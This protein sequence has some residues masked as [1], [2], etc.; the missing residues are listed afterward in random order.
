VVQ[1]RY[2]V[3]G[4]QGGALI[5]RFLFTCLVTHGPSCCLVRS[6]FAISTELLLDA[7]GEHDSSSGGGSGGGGGGGG[8][9]DDGD[10]GAAS[11]SSGGSGQTAGSGGDTGAG[12]G[13]YMLQPTGRYAHARS[14]IRATAAAASWEAVAMDGAV[15]RMNAGKPIHGT[16]CVLRLL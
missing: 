1:A 12:S 8:S 15:I 3:G 9:G 13:G 10:A 6:L 7:G 5:C 11:G 2:C 4:G 16:L 14:Y